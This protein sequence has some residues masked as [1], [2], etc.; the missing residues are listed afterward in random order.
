MNKRAVFT[1]ICVGNDT[2][3]DHKNTCILLI[4][5][6]IKHT[7]YSIVIVTDDV[8][9]FSKQELGDRV[10]LHN[11]YEHTQQPLFFLNFFN[12]NLKYIPIK[13]AFKYECDYTIYVDCDTF[14]N[15]WDDNYLVRFDESDIDVLAPYGHTKVGTA[16]QMKDNRTALDKF[17]EIGPY[18]DDSMSNGPII[19]ETNIVFKKNLQKQAD[20]IDMFEKIA[21]NSIKY[22]TQKTFESWFFGACIGYAKMKFQ[23]V[24]DFGVDHPSY[25]GS[26]YLIH[27]GWL[28]TSTTG[29]I[30]PYN[31]QELLNDIKNSK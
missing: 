21:D 20:F 13:I 19:Q 25:M 7:P 15:S 17:N 31:F 16:E 23:N 10:I 28:C 4:N 11:I 6:I 12:C 1:T 27:A 22:N 9:F 14:L 3:K 5:S 24:F 18:W 8:D 2:W 26:W 29:K 30:K